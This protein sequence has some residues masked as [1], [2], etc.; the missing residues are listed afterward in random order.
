MQSHL[1]IDSAA[2]CGV[3]TKGDLQGAVCSVPSVN[4]RQTASYGG[5][6]SSAECAGGS[7]SPGAV[8]AHC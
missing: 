7:C 3:K 2:Q 1:G 5:G 8:R 4:A 6:N